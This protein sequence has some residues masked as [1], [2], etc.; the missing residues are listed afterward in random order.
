MVVVGLWQAV[1]DH[2]ID[3]AVLLG[4]VAIIPLIEIIDVLV[5]FAQKD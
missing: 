4:M 3:P 5:V 2:M 1:F